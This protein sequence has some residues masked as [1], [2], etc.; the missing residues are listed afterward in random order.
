MLLK[1]VIFVF[2]CEMLVQDFTRFDKYSSKLDISRSFLTIFDIESKIGFTRFDK[3][4]SKL[5]ISRSFLTIFADV[6]Q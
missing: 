6:R 3:Y 2:K 5:G 1:V 4:S